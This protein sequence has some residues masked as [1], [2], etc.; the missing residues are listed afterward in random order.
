M[1]YVYN[2]IYI[3]KLRHKIEIFIKYDAWPNYL[4]RDGHRDYIDSSEAISSNI[5]VKI[6]CVGTKVKAAKVAR[7]LNADNKPR[8]LFLV[9]K[10]G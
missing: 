8:T 10:Y 7:R 5:T 4:K 2:V 9:R 1:L 6:S 3:V